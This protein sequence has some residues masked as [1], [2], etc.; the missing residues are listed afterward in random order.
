MNI[1]TG[2]CNI[3][4]IYVPCFN[5]A[6]CLTCGRAWEDG[7]EITTHLKSQTMQKKIYIA[8]K[9]TGEPIHEVTMRFGA[10]E[11]EL[12]EQGHQVINPLA[13][14]IGRQI[15][16]EEIMKECI[17]A[18]FEC[19]EVHLLPCWQG[20]KGAMLERHIAESLNIKVVYPKP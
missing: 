4:S 5:Y 6:N 15:R 12:R 14:S 19:D 7:E 18:M 17:T 9:I 1:C 11:K 16:W 3:K 10:K 13:L 8:G 20:S 2:N